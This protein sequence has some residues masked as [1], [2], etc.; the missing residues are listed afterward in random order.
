MLQVRL[1]PDLQI[2]L[3]LGTAAREGWQMLGLS[4]PS[5]AAPHPSN[6]NLCARPWLAEEFDKAV[7]SAAALLAH[8]R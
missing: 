2:V 8:G 6:T 3:T 5:I 1:L 4:L 7:L